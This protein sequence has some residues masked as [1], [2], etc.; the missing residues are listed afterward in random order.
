MKRE[1]NVSVEV[2]A[3]RVAYREAITKRADFDWLHKKQSGGQGQYARVVGYLEPAP[4][5]DDDGGGGCG[6]NR[7]AK[8]DAGATAAAAA[9]GEGSSSSSAELSS[10]DLIF[11]RE[12]VGNAVPPSFIPAVEK[13]FRE[14]AASSSLAG[15]P[16]FGARIALTDGA[17]HAVDSSELAFK[18]AATYA[19]RDAYARA[20]PQLL[21]PVMT[22]D[23]RVPAEF[24]GAVVGDVHRRKGTVAGA[25]ADGPDDV[26]L[27][28]SVPLS[29]MFGYSTALRSMTQGKGE[30]TMEYSHHAPVPGDAA[31]EL[32]AA[33]GKK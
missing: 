6:G 9:A 16:V 20:G 11:S 30:F 5:S 3:P 27:R 33:K 32:I 10:S 8:N 29:A 31:K 12:T 26:A 4:K 17:A 13:G 24:Q 28:A 2:G 23:V 25:K 15:H 7:S 1:Y 18:L 19:F 21:E 22:V 14:A